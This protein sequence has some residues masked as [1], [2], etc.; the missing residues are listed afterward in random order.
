M[1][2][3]L[4]RSVDSEREEVVASLVVVGEGRRHGNTR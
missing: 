4:E 2:P 1:C 3:A